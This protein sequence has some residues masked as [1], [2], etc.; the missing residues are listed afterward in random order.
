MVSS[1]DLGALYRA[2]NFYLLWV[3][4][5]CSLM[6]DQIMLVG[7]PFLAIQAAGVSSAQAALLPFF[8]YLPFLLIS[9]VVGALVDILPRRETMLCAEIVQFFLFVCLLIFMF[10]QV[11]NFYTL[12]FLCFSIG[13][14]NVF[15]QVSYNSLLPELGFGGDNLHVANSRLLFSE[16]IARTLG[17]ACAGYLIYYFTV[18]SIPIINIVSF[19]ISVLTIYL[20]K[21]EKIKNR[22][23]NT[24][25][26]VRNLI[27]DVKKGLSYVRSHSILEPIF[28]CGF[29]YVIFL[30][31]S[32]TGLILYCQE[33][34]KMPASTIGIL[35][36]ATAVGFPIA[37]ILAP[38]VI[39]LFGVARTL[40]F[41]AMFSVFGLCALAGG[42][43][44]N[45]IP[46]MVLASALHGLGE[47]IFNPTALTSRQIATPISMLG[48]VNSVQKFLT[49]GAISIGSLLAAAVINFASL[50]WILWFGGIGTALCLFPLV[51]KGIRKD[52]L[53]SF[54]KIDS[55]SLK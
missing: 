41:S 16:S 23:T 14:T 51:R 49:W 18:A 32:N 46:I 19:F 6:G 45:S 1:V 54:V 27:G 34:L 53:N 47:G 11:L 8:L 33:I 21:T 29:V 4:Q 36:G 15:F 10:N 42:A 25:L 5:S 55:R 20:I 3:G 38:Y 52:L 26:V 30:T 12:S 31:S 22:K 40:V 7:L 39:R 35:V 13:L 37:N 9:L 24:R 48:R 44:I 43:E 50:E 28:S 17:P 2:R